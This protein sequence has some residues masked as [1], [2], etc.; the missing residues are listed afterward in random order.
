LEKGKKYIAKIYSDDS[1]ATTA[2]KVKVEQIKV[3]ASSILNVKL[4]PSG[5]QS[6]WIREEK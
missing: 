2:T 6:I 3:N 5:G 1:T 4:L